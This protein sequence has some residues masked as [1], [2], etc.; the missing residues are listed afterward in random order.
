MG[1]KIDLTVVNWL[2]HVLDPTISHTKM[3]Y[4]ADEKVMLKIFLDRMIRNTFSFLNQAEVS[5]SDT[6]SLVELLVRLKRMGNE[7]IPEDFYAEFHN[8]LGRKQ[9]IALIIPSGT[10]EALDNMLCDPELLGY[11]V[12][13]SPNIQGLILQL[14]EAPK[15]ISTLIDVHEVLRIALNDLISWPGILIWYPGGDSVFLPISSVDFLEIDIEA[16]VQWVFSKLFTDLVFDLG[17]MKVEYKIAFPEVFE[18]ENNAVNILHLSDMQIGSMSSN[19][20]LSRFR[21]F[22]WQLVEELHG[23]SKIVPVITGNLMDSPSEK[24]LGLVRS[25]WEFLSGL[26]V[27]E[28]LFV[29]GNK[30]VRRD[31]NI[32]ESYRTAVGFP[33]TKVIWF[34][35]EKLGLV[36]INSVMN[37]NPQYGSIDQQQLDEI[38]YELE[39]KKNYKDYNLVLLLHHPVIHQQEDKVNFS[40]YEKITGEPFS[41]SEVIKGAEKLLDFSQQ[42]SITAI[43]HGYRHF[44]LIGKTKQSIPVVGCGSSIGRLSK[45]DGSVYFSVNI[46][47]INQATRKFSARLLAYRKPGGGLTGYKCHEIVFRT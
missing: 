28:P 42:N 15:A 30:D 26:G 37:G 13:A 23:S 47:S 14:E 21:Q 5:S 20:K 16:R 38:K 18:H 7:R 27:E 41:S 34:D 39:R 40:F 12:R 35:D 9:W 46:I 31:G 22:I 45:T 17:R 44:P 36:C 2:A 4:D 24:H 43:L 33:I 25:F 19:Q 10:D 32:N 29:L 6:N 8:A 11:L 1:K 3:V